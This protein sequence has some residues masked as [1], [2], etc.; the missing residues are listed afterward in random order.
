MA[1][2]ATTRDATT[3]AMT[4]GNEEEEEEEEKEKFFELVVLDFDL[5]VLSIHSFATRIRAE[6][7]RDGTRDWAKDFV[8]LK[9]L[10]RFY[11]AS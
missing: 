9:Y 6:D 7:V 11:G 3:S 1:R 10:E 2:D 8:D 4:R 5:T